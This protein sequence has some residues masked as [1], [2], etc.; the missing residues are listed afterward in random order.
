MEIDY[1]LTIPITLHARFTLHGFT[2]L[3]GRSGTGKTLLLKALAGLIPAT[4]TPWP[5]LA[6]EHRPIGYLPQGS[7][8]FPHLTALENAAFGLTGPTRL[9]QA[10][11]LLDTLGIG[12]LTTRRTHALSG[13]EAQRVALARALARK[14]ALLL[15]DEPSAALD[16]ATRDTILTQLI[17]TIT[18]ANIPAL[19]AT[20]DPSLAGLADWL[21]LIDNGNVIQQ[22]TPGN[23]FNNPTS[24]AAAELLGYQNIWTHNQTTYCIRAEHIEIK[25]TGHPATITAIREQGPNLRLTCTNTTILIK[26]GNKTN[27]Q[28][29]QQIMLDFPE[30]K[31]KQLK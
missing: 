30:E 13:G 31:V 18:T 12:H 10:Q 5:N 22:G 24:R 27:Y 28:I 11:T 2:A 25:P 1:H 7:A 9:T 14:P 16:P 15:L 3:L 21:V 6:P 4:G 8:L 17:D 20:H 19:A 29:G 23:I 26:D